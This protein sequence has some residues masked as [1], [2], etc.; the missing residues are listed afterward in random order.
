VAGGSNFNNGNSLGK[1]GIKTEFQFKKMA[2]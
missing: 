2:G 1:V